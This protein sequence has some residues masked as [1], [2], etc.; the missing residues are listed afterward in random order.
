MDTLTL[1]LG[2]EA[3]LASGFEVRRAD[4][5]GPVV[6]FRGYASVVGV[7]YDV[8]GGPEM[9]GWTETMAPGAFKRTLGKPANR[10]LLFHH[11]SSRV[12]A[13]TRAGSL[14]MAEDEVGLLVTA[15]LDTRVSWIADL[16]T[17][18]ESG[19]IDEMSIGFYAKN[20]EWSKDYSQRT[21]N[22]VQLVESTITWA[23]ANGAT[24][25]A[26]E[27]SRDLVTEARTAA[28]VRNFDRVAVAARAAAA[29]LAL[30]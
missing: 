27:R 18:V 26:I 2:R 3:R 29:S 16:V 12:L 14:T 6:E 13:T 19:T 23:G 17:Q 4:E 21:V 8:A 22:E 15:A 1:D 5:H 10:A 20:S 30:R 7:P 9:G 28:P 25:A 11:D 24:V